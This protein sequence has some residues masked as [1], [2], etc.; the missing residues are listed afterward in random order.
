[1]RNYYASFHTYDSLAAQIAGV[2]QKYPDMLVVGSLGRATVF[3]SLLGDPEFEYTA[4]GQH[5][6]FAGDTARDIDVIGA[7]HDFVVR[8]LPFW[9]DATSYDIGGTSIAKHGSDWVISVDGHYEAALH[10]STMEPIEAETI[11]GI[12]CM[13]LPAETQLALLRVRGKFRE[14]DVQTFSLLANL[15]DGRERLP[16]ELYRPFEDVHEINKARLS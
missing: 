8:T 6:L 15:I 5:S 4:R 13:T 7:E 9:V 16:V 11:Y 14:K 3:S 1:M 12:P 2:Y 10:P